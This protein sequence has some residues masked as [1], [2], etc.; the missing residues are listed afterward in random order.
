MLGASPEPQRGRGPENASFRPR[1]LRE[2]LVLPV[3]KKPTN[4]ENPPIGDFIVQMSSVEYNIKMM[5]REL[6]NSTTQQI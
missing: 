5:E 2:N 4:T 3:N 1:N 6:M